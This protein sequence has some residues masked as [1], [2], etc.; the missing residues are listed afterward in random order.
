M[1]VIT[2]DFFLRFFHLERWPI[3]EEEEKVLFCDRN[4]S[5]QKIS[6]ISRDSSKEEN[7][8]LHHV[9]PEGKNLGK[10]MSVKCFS[11][12]LSREISVK[13]IRFE[14]VDFDSK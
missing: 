7:F 6:R 12:F 13:I 11:D 4:V 8:L 2:S 5:R 10:V 3:V 1:F 9:G 14:F